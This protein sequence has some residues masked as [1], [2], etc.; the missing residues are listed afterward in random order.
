MAA[1]E[2]A[3]GL[4]GA[5]TGPAGNRVAV[6]EWLAQ[7]DGTL[8]AVTA[9]LVP[10]FL[11]LTYRSP[12]LWLLPFVAAASALVTARAAA[13][14]VAQSGVII[15]DQ[16]GNIV[17]VLV[18]G[19]GTDYALLLVARYREALLVTKDRYAAMRTALWSPGRLGRSGAGRRGTAE[20]YDVRQ[21]AQRDN[22]LVMPLV[23]LAVFLVLLALLRSPVASAVLLASVV[24]S[25]LGALGLGT[26]ILRTTL[27]YEV[28]DA[29][30]PIFAFVFLI[31]LGVDYNI[32]LVT[33][34][35][36]E[37]AA[38]TTRAGTLRALVATGPVITSAGLVLAG[39]FAA[40]AVLSSVLLVQV[41]FI[42]ALGVLI[43]TTLSGAC[44]CRRSSSLSANGSGGRPPGPP[45]G[46]GRTDHAD[47]R[48]RWPGCR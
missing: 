1:T 6:D 33:R 29:T 5:V 9:G 20:E 10:V 18:F 39:T 42:V 30:V 14:V 41:G 43:D 44:W 3:T 12:V 35:R 22:R 16:S 32:F 27:G 13:W 31:A 46:R 11:M 36:E 15:N 23:L 24:L 17:P 8:L 40:L 45:E 21:S 48:R 26:L 7:V 2:A 25:F 19:A 34:I 47:L 37:A 28:F 38:T 4:S